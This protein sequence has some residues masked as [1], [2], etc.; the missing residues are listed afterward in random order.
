M[1]DEGI[2]DY[3][4]L[5][6]KKCNSI[7]TF[8]MKFSIDVVF[9]DKNYKVMRIYRNKRPWRLTP[10]V[11][12]ASQVLEVESGKLPFLLSEGDKLEVVCTN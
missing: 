2:E 9:L 11:L 3:D 6:I 10:L 1:F 5:L 7:H 12:G 8:F 4:G